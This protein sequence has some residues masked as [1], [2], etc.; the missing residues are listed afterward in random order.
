MTHL[1]H[2]WNGPTLAPFFR[3]MAERFRF[4]RFDQRGNRLS[5][6]NP[7][8]ISFDLFVRDTEA[9]VDAAGLERIP[10]YGS[11]QG[12]AV[13]ASYAVRRPERVSALT[14]HGGYARGRYKR[15]KPSANERMKVE[16]LTN[17]ALSEF[18]RMG[19]PHWVKKPSR[20]RPPGGHADNRGHEPGKDERCTHATL[21]LKATYRRATKAKRPL[22]FIV[23][24]DALVPKP[25]V[26]L[27]RFHGVFAPKRSRWS[28]PGLGSRRTM[29]TSSRSTGVF[30]TN[31]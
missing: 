23:R 14:L 1:E 16:A 19:T 22:D 6:R 25:R 24:L 12:A 7:G 27:I 26:N 29:P 4:V 3:A 11:S 8:E 5:D 20:L 30:A 2:G 18:R 28:S 13:A 9:V 31:A 15:G 10:I 21:L 17:A